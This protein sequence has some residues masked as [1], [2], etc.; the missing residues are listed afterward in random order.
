MTS[1]KTCQAQLAQLLARPDRAWMSSRSLVK[2]F[3]LTMSNL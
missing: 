2:S 3:D 1:A